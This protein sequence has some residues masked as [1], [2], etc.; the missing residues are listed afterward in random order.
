[1]DNPDIVFFDLDHTPINTDCEW[2][3]KNMPTDM[4]LVPDSQ[5]ALLRKWLEAN[6]SESM[7]KICTVGGEA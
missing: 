5:R 2:A 4:I 6:A 7:P 3:W 1:M